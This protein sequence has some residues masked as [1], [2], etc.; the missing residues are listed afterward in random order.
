MSGMEVFGATPSSQKLVLEPVVASASKTCNQWQ[1]SCWRCPG[2]LS[3]Q[4]NRGWDCK[5]CEQ[6]IFLQ[7]ILE[8]RPVFCCGAWDASGTRRN[9]LIDS[10]QRRGPRRWDGQTSPPH[11]RAVFGRMGEGEGAH[12]AFSASVSFTYSRLKPVADWYPW[13]H[14]RTLL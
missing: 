9:C 4:H 13:Y 6:V 3:F 5:A 8:H 12:P 14:L 7:D 11:Q 1:F 2:W 10:V